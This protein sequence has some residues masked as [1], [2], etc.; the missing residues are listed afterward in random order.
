MNH[1]LENVPWNEPL[2]HD[3]LSRVCN[4]PQKALILCGDRGIFTS[5][6]LA[7]YSRDPLCPKS[8]VAHW[9]KRLPHA[10]VSLVPNAGAFVLLTHD[11]E[12]TNALVSFAASNK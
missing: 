10:R 1:V 3:V 5:F 12:C 4:H 6:F 8:L 2:D 9:K 7:H 11:K